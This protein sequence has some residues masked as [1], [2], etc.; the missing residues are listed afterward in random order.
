MAAGGERE[1]AEW[2]KWEKGDRAREVVIGGE[3]NHQR[4]EIETETVGGVEGGE[5]GVEVVKA[6]AQ[7]G[8]ADGD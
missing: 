1:T 2:R 3:D 4:L 6:A 5:V 7:D 8:G